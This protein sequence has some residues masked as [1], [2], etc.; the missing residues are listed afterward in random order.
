MSIIRKIIF[1]S[2]YIYTCISFYTKRTY[3]SILLY[4]Y[5]RNIFLYVPTFNLISYFQDDDEFKISINLCAYTSDT[6]TN[7][8]S[9]VKFLLYHFGDSAIT[10]K[11]YLPPCIKIIYPFNNSIYIHNVNFEKN[12]ISSQNIEISGKTTD[13][14]FD[15]NRMCFEHN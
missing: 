15:F 14:E 1:T 4:L 12:M 13:Y 9:R 10:L 2:I 7:I 8:T 3:Q 6:N 5:Q 11:K